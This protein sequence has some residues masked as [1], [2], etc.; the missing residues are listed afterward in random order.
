M[1][2]MDNTKVIKAMEKQSLQ[3]YLEKIIET[4]MKKV[5][6]FPIF[7]QTGAPN[8]FEPASIIILEDL[9][10]LTELNIAASKN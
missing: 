7:S 8:L 10:K 9:T 4:K 6:L 3:K 2:S 5:T 1:K